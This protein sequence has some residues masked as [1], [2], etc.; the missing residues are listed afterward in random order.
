MQEKRKRQRITGMNKKIVLAIALVGISGSVIASSLFLQYSPVKNAITS[1]TQHTPI[2]TAFI[3][4]TSELTK[5]EIDDLIKMREEE[6]LAH[7]VYTTLGTYWN[8]P[9]F[10]NIAASEAQHTE[11]VKSLLDS[12]G[13]PDP[14]KN[15]SV[16]V[17]TDPAM[18]ELYDSLIT[19]GRV[20]AVEALKVGALIEDLD[21]ADLDKALAATENSAITSVYTNL[22]RGSE[23][24]MRAFVGQ[25][26]RYNATYSPTY[27]DEAEYQRILND[28][29]GNRQGQMRSN[30]GRGNGRNNGMNRV[31]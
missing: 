5:V 25:L 19:K 31:F 9:V 15:A 28:S 18:K 13:L 10:S 23:N 8:I 29:Q 30:G 2:G 7:D 27:I 4:S 11:Q 22:R 16:G 17:F 12:Y 1:L 20:S 6:K 14:V 24:H 26:T 3:A 21:I